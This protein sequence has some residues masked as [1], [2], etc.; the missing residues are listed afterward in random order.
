MNFAGDQAVGSDLGSDVDKR[1]SSAAL[2]VTRLSP[3][4]VCFAFGLHY[5][6]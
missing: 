4:F 3:L 5:H 6:G 2:A 1:S